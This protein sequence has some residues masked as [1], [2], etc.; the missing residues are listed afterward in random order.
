MVIVEKVYNTTIEKVWTAL[1]DKEE[2][3]QWYFSLDDFRPEVGFEFRF[4]GQGHK[5]EQYMHI[6][7]ITEVIRYKR[8]QY[9][10]RYENYQGYS[11]VTFELSDEGNQTRLKL[12]HDGLETFPKNN[13]DFA[14]ESFNTGWTELIT[15]LLTQYL[16]KTQ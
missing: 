12:T 16:E 11:I 15:V 3:K 2:M 9:S 1:T 6:C 14:R 13:S 5:G 10:W 7:K 4:P 8:L